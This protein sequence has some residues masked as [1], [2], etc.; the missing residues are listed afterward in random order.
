MP[1]HPTP[2]SSRGVATATATAMVVT[3]AGALEI[4]F[5][6]MLRHHRESFDVTTN[7]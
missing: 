6:L 1:P 2:A 4:N 7:S 5:G 3:D